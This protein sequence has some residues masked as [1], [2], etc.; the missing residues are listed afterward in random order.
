[1]SGEVV[2]SGAS[3]VRLARVLE[4]DSRL[5]GGDLSTREALAQLADLPCNNSMPSAAAEFEAFA[6]YATD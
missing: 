3:H 4:T 2:I 6:R 5:C 1:M